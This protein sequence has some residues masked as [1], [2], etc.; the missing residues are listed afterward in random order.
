MVI[1]FLNWYN[2]LKS[3]SLFCHF[4]IYVNTSGLSSLK[5]ALNVVCL[6][7][8]LTSKVFSLFMLFKLFGCFYSVIT[9]FLLSRDI[10]ED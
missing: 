2:H 4:H 7:L 5:G 6:V 1:I 10:Q 8:I 3:I 9:Q